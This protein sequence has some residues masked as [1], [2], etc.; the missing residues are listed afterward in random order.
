MV[1]FYSGFPLSI[2]VATVMRLVGASSGCGGW[3]GDHGRVVGQAKFRGSSSGCWSRAGGVLGIACFE[4]M[5]SVI[6]GKRTVTPLELQFGGAF[7]LDVSDDD[8]LDE[9]IESQKS[10]SEEQLK[11]ERMWNSIESIVDDNRV[12][13]HLKH[14]RSEPV[15][16]VLSVRLRNHNQTDYTSESWELYGTIYV[17]DSMGRVGIGSN[18]VVLFERE[19]EIDDPEIIP[20]T[21]GALSLFGPHSVMSMDKPV[22]GIHLSDKVTGDT[23]IFN[24]APLLMTTDTPQL[25]HQFEQFHKITVPGAACSAEVEY[26]ALTFAVYAHVEVQLLKQVAGS[27]IYEEDEQDLDIYGTISAKYNLYDSEHKINC[28]TLF[29]INKDSDKTEKVNLIYPTNGITLSRSVVAVPSYSL[30]TIQLKLWDR[31]KN[32]LI[33][34]GS[35]DFLTSNYST[36][37]IIVGRNCVNAKV[38]IKWREP[39]L[40]DEPCVE[41][42]G[43]LN[44]IRFRL[45]PN[46]P[47]IS[48]D[49]VVEVFSVFIGRQND[50]QLSL[51]GMV[52]YN[53]TF[54]LLNLFERD[55]TDPFILSSGCNFLPLK[56]PK[57]AL[58]PGDR[59]FVSVDLQDVEGRVSIKGLAQSNLHYPGHLDH[60]QDCLLC[61]VIGHGQK[62]SFAAIHYTL[63]SHALKATLKIR[64]LFNG[65]Q[66]VDAR[67]KIYGNLVACYGKYGSRTPYEK[68]Y[69]RILLFE[70]PEDNSLEVSCKEFDMELSRPVVAVP[71]DSSLRIA[72]NLSCQSSGFTQ[73]LRAQGNFK[74]LMV[75]VIV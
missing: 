12:W 60:W 15:I 9:I 20:L 51:Y 63:F 19:E 67:C 71:I 35:Y 31:A 16:E 4:D 1:G 29:D 21:G 10:P 38:T 72:V 64:F 2:S 5:A 66:S 54:G 44:K 70:R 33:V 57:K 75:L 25:H 46:A 8:E 22:I 47:N 62:N 40:L 48:V 32:E 56:G 53:S 28:F 65:E 13:Q 26:L 11:K 59:Y 49:A 34:E 39:F 74:L 18:R 55:E 36:D 7:T 23:L 17:H 24:Y 73:L 61:S 43:Y 14:I 30:L 68:L 52:N 50:E 27:V 41:S 58:V 42:H 6:S 45:P 69:H 3:G 37:K